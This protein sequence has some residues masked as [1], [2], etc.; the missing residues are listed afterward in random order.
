M[1]RSKLKD[2]L[3]DLVQDLKEF[4]DGLEFL[5]PEPTL[6]AHFHGKI[7]AFQDKLEAIDEPLFIA[8]IGGTGVGKSALINALAGKVISKSSARRAFTDHKVFFCHRRRVDQILQYRFFQEGLDEISAHEEPSLEDVV[9]IDLPD[10]DSDKPSHP[11]QVN[12]MIPHLDITL[13]LVDHEKYNDDLLHEEYLANLVSYQKSFIFVFNRI[14]ELIENKPDRKQARQNLEKL[15]E[16]FQEVLKGEGYS[17]IPPNRIFK[18]SAKR[19]LESKQGQ[20]KEFDENEF[21]RLEKLIRDQASMKQM[22]QMKFLEDIHTMLLEFKTLLQFDQGLGRV[23]RYRHLLMDVRQNPLTGLSKMV[24]DRLVGPVFTEN[25]RKTLEAAS[26]N[27]VDLLVGGP[28]GFMISFKFRLFSPFYMLRQAASDFKGYLRELTGTLSGQS[29][30]KSLEDVYTY[31]DPWEAFM[32]LEG[33]YHRLNTFLREIR[34]GWEG[35]LSSPL[36]PSRFPISPLTRDRLERLLEVEKERLKVYL[37]EDYARLSRWEKW[38]SRQHLVPWSATV[39]AVGLPALSYISQISLYE[40]RLDEILLRLQ[41]MFLSLIMV[42]LLGYFLEGMVIKRRIRQTLRRDLDRL[43]EQM[44]KDLLKSLDENLL[45]P[46]ETLL[47]KYETT[48]RRLEAFEKR[49]QELQSK[50]SA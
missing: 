10:I 18:V 23:E 49:F 11:Q 20:A 46:V 14:D 7:K 32:D 12:Q 36:S 13:W 26:M 22:S 1:A 9:L 15:V 3:R 27:R 30:E 34:R 33:L 24:E 25:L 5:N 31:L 45:Q 48:L 21:S 42:P 40:I 16:H 4:A 38:R 2:Q 37:R 6:L 41:S 47:M 17:H 29:Q 35:G 39:I 8:L 43:K 28:L 19:A 50:V 44:K